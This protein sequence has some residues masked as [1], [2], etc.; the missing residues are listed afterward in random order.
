MVLRYVSAAWDCLRR[1]MLSCSHCSLLWS[2][3]D[4]PQYMV[5]CRVNWILSPVSM[6]QLLLVVSYVPSESYFRT[7]DMISEVL[8]LL[9]YEFCN[10]HVHFNICQ[11][12]VCTLVALP[13]ALQISGKAAQG[14]FGEFSCCCC[15]ECCWWNVAMYLLY[16]RCHRLL[17]VFSFWA[18]LS[19]RRSKN[20]ELAHILV[21]LHIF[22]HF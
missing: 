19:E 1:S 3:I 17:C 4:L 8:K 12:L 2:R 21:W 15:Q 16:H 10:V 20:I 14:L 18:W 9:R 13:F 5:F 11:G 7:C 6:F 22:Q